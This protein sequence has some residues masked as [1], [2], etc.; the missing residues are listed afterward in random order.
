MSDLFAQLENLSQTD[1]SVRLFNAVFGQ[2]WE[3]LSLGGSGTG[4]E[5]VLGDLL[6][7]C[8]NV[9]NCCCAVVVAWLFILTTVCATLGAAQDGRG[10]GG[11]RYSSAWIPLRYSFAMGAITPVFSGL[12]AMQLL[13]MS[14]IGLSVQFA[15]TLWQAGLEH[16]SRTGSVLARSSPAVSASAAQVLPVMLQHAVL[17]DYFLRVERCAVADRPSAR[18]EGWSLN[19]YVI[20]LE[21]PR[22]LNCP[23]LRGDDGFG[24]TLN[25]ALHFG[26]FGAV[27]ISTPVPEAS[28]ALAETLDAGGPLCRAVERGALRAL[29]GGEGTPYERAG[30]GALARL[31]QDSVS[32]ALTAAAREAEERRGKILADFAEKAGRQGWWMAG[33]YYWTLAR[34]AADAVETMQDRTTATPVNVEALSD[35]L[36]PELERALRLARELGQSAAIIAGGGSGAR[37]PPG[38]R[39]P[40]AAGPLTERAPDRED[41]SLTARLT[42]FFSGAS[43]AL[44]EFRLD[45]A[46]AGLGAAGLIS[47]NDMVFNV[48]KAAR[49]LM[50]VCENAVLGYVAA[51]LTV[52]G[53]G[54]FL[55]NPV[56][57]AAVD[58][59]EGVL[60]LAGKIA[61]AIAAPLWIVCWFY[62][63][64][65]PMLPFLAWFTA[66][67]G[68]LV[69]CLEA[70]AACPVWLIS[71]C[72]PEGDGFAGVSARAGYALFLSVLLRP[73]LL[74]LSFFLCL[75]VL[76]VSGS[77]MGELLEPFFEA[78]SGAFGTGGF[79]TTG[80]GVTASIS[81]VILTGLVTGIAGWK[82]FALV[83]VIPD[84]IIRW[85][86]QLMAS[87]GDFSAERT[88]QQGQ[89]SMDT[90][91]G[92]LVPGIAAGTAVAAVAG[93]GAR[94]GPRRTGPSVLDEELAQGSRRA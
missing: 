71:H 6:F 62:A 41:G 66:I 75:C 70:V 64:M 68:W 49:S 58:A 2:G 24:M 37:P 65:L 47:G 32:S 73:M 54:A 63:Y 26:D 33:S 92:R 21:L 77:F 60:D 7:T 9:L 86:G 81:T 4:S 34:T 5:A 52:H 43:H 8:F 31:Y 72:M 88:L 85:A 87:L 27:H 39:D 14:S 67:L 11:S 57:G 50:N 35:F 23:S 38:V 30:V 74:V 55:R 78:Q 80:W 48:V 53:L 94:S 56:T 25:P 20:R 13:M 40:A 51:K 18:E 46:A 61:L 91:A 36:N 89:V 45:E 28:R 83:T 42:G 16:L 17:K 59:V 84:R 22:L 1:L 93:I 10:V 82:L 79:G 19:R 3:R 76:S 15:D 29:R 90:A 44:S 12:N 69:L